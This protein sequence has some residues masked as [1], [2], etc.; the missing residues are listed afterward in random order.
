M[1]LKPYMAILTLL[2]THLALLMYLGSVCKST[3]SK[4]LVIQ[5]QQ[6]EYYICGL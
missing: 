5:T 4:Y 6:I 1:I 2:F 3:L